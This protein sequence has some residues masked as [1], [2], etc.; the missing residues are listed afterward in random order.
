MSLFLASFLSLAQFQVFGFDISDLLRY[1]TETSPVVEIKEGDCLRGPEIQV[2]LGVE[3]P[4]LYYTLECGKPYPVAGDLIQHFAC[5]LEGLSGR[6]SR[7]IKEDDQ[8][9]FFWPNPVPCMSFVTSLKYAKA[10]YR[11]LPT[12]IA[13]VTE[14]AQKISDRVESMATKKFGIGQ[15]Q[16]YLPNPL[17]VKNIEYGESSADQAASVTACNQREFRADYLGWGAFQMEWK[18]IDCLANKETECQRAKV[19][20]STDAEGHQ[21]ALVKKL[22]QCPPKDEPLIFKKDL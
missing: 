16:A 17:I 8:P 10:H 1:R 20:A 15:G 13:C 2:F 12:D 21:C 5:G 19:E 22:T 4:D 18:K 3:N 7:E 6:W 9:G 14:N 11:E